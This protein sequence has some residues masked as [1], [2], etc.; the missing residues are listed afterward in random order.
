M[1]RVLHNDPRRSDREAVPPF[2]LQTERAGT[3][4]VD[5]SVAAAIRQN[6]SWAFW[7]VK[8]ELRDGTRMADLVQDV[9]IEVT[10]RLKADEDVGLNLNGYIRTSIIRRVRTIAIRE[11]R[12]SYE[13]A[14]HDLEASYQ[15][16]APN[17][18]KV[19]ED[20]ITLQSLAPFMSHPVR[21]ILHYRMA[22]YSWKRIAQLTGLTEKQAKSR[23]YYGARQAHE[24]LI[25]GQ[26]K[27]SDPERN[28]SNG[29][30]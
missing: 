13:G 2:W 30:Q 12:V 4:V 16:A 28:P 11:C 27:R 6:W 22:D 20:R 14:A 29:R 15:P 1:A 3:I 23:F 17:W 5:P 18:T 19:F 21:T 8:R 7:L 10:N 26:K 25:S 9:A 24:E